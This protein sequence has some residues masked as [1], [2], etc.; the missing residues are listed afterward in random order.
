MGNEAWKSD[1]GNLG[2]RGGFLHSLAVRVYE[3]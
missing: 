3:I 1:T 2:W